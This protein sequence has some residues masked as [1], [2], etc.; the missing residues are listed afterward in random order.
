MPLD[1]NA[2]VVHQALKLVFSEHRVDQIDR[3]FARDF[4]QHSPYATSGGREEL[5][6]EIADTGPLVRLAAMQ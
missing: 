2:K 6:W 3:L 4:V 5:H 1:T